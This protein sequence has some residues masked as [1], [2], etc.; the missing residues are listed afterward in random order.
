[1]I[2]TLRA[3]M[4]GV[5]GIHFEGGDIVTRGF[6]GEIS[7][8]NVSKLPPIEAIDRCVRCLP[9]RFDEHAG[10][11]VEQQSACDIP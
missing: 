9:L 6:T 1:M 3:H 5:A 2:W 10:G 11:L 7:R 8:W 4:V